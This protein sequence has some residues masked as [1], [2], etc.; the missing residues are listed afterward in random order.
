MVR[1]KNTGVWSREGFIA[2]PSQKNR[3]LMFKTPKVPDGFQGEVFIGK[4][5]GEG[6]KVCDFL[7]MVGGEVTGLC[8]LESGGLPKVPSLCLAEGLSS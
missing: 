3:W 7:L 5:W 8:F 1:P 6:C 2:G 4:S